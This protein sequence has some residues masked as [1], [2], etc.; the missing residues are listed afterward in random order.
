[1]LFLSTGPEA[2]EARFFGVESIRPCPPWT[3][4]DYLFER[5]VVK[6]GLLLI[7]AW[8]PDPRGPF[9]FLIV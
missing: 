1:M 5:G 2:S 8:D 6:G 9:I 4:A 7:V 3:S